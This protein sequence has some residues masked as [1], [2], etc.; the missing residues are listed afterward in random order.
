MVEA[1]GIEPDTN[2]N[3]I[4]FFSLSGTSQERNRERQGAGLRRTY[5]YC[6]RSAAEY[7]TILDLWQVGL[8]EEM[9]WGIFPFR[10][11]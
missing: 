7:L 1:T 4:A 5:R 9:F 11:L 6:E 10:R 2:I 3:I 8:E